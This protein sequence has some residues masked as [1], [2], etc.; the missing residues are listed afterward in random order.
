MVLGIGRDPTQPG[1][2]H[3]ASASR[4]GWMAVRELPS[5]FPLGME[6]PSSM[7]SN[8]PPSPRHVQLENGSDPTDSGTPRTSH[9]RCQH[10]GDEREHAGVGWVYQVSAGHEQRASVR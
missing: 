7:L 3:P 4:S 10:P 8:Q 1:G 6:Y 9:V 5:S 2:G